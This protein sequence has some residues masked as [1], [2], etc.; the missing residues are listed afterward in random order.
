M[1]RPATRVSRLVLALASASLLCT[2]APRAGAQ[3][4]PDSARIERLKAEALTKIEARSKLVQEMIDHQF[5]FS[6]LGFQEFETQKYLTGIL[7]QAGFDITLGY[8]GMPSAWVARWSNGS[9]KP[10]IALGSDVDGIPQSNNK[11]GVG[12]LDPQVVGA[13]G[14][15]EGHNTGQAVNIA[16]ALVVKEIMTREKIPGTLVLWPG[17]AEEQMAGKAF[18]VR[19]GLFKDADVALFTHV[20]N[21]L[22][23]SW[24]ASGQSA[25]ISAI[26]QFKGT[27][28]HA[29]G[30]PWR[31]RSALDAAMLM[32]TGWEYQREHNELPTRS[33]YVIMDGGDQPNVVPSTASIWFYFRERDYER[34]K[35][36]FETGKRIAQGAALMANVEL[37]TVMM[38][39]SG[40]SGHFNKTIAEVT[41]DNIK[42]VGMP[43]WDD[44]DQTLAKGLQKELGARESGLSTASEFAMGTPVPES[45]MLGGGS[46]DIGDVSWNLPT[47]TLRY[48]SNIPGLPG[49][50]WSSSIASATPIAHKGAVQGAKV[51]ALTLIDILMKPQVVADAWTYFRD[52]QTKDVKYVP[53]ISATDK[54]PIWMNADIMARYKPELQKHYYD[55]K[56]YK[57]YLEQLG[58]AYPTTRETLKP[59]MDN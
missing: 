10:V 18:L 44:A 55:A 9:G 52:V 17:I 20:G 13:P 12:F 4:A 22:G 39:G 16:A 30:S 1:S 7:K 11:P 37:D 51:Q 34:T 50:N 40:W 35:A 45:R 25:L 32:G 42:R 31:G 29:A 2:I 33:H 58:I 14:H 53:F 46:D 49:H 43:A 56:K 47:V 27:S 26:F 3:A 5:S 8:A 15:G 28:A 48:P 57:S 23:V 19:E 36:L 41:F 38:V 54:P 59:K 21:G 24:G 6:E